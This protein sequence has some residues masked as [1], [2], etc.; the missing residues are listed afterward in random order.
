MPKLGVFSG[1]EIVRILE[2]EGF[3]RAR[4]KGSHLI[5]QRRAEGGTITVPVRYIAW[6]ELA[7]CNP[8]FARVESFANAFWCELLRKT[9]PLFSLLFAAATVM[10][11]QQPPV[12]NFSGDTWQM[13]E[14]GQAI[15]GP[16]P[17]FFSATNVSVDAQGRLHLAISYTNGEWRCAE[18]TLDNSLGYC[19]YRLTLDS[20][21]SDFSS[22][23]FHN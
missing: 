3:F 23:L 1:E 20:D 16:G 15:V 6:L 18:V 5:M 9:L 12:I 11:G 4:Q 17:N 14:R 21:V 8:S 19:T 10:Q 22:V 13:K 2:S 7:H